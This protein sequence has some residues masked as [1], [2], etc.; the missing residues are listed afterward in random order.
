ML[1][2]AEPGQEREKTTKEEAGTTQKSKSWLRHGSFLLCSPFLTYRTSFV[3]EII[4]PTSKKVP[5]PAL[6][7]QTGSIEDW[8]NLRRGSAQRL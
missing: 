2:P 1:Q 4:M 3:R 6:Q 7:G 8:P 5:S